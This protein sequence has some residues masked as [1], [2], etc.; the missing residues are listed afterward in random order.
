MKAYL[1]EI[2]LEDMEVP[3]TDNVFNGPNY[4]DETFRFLV[5]DETLSKARYSAIT[6]LPYDYLECYELT[7]LDLFRSTKGKRTRRKYNYSQFN[8]R[9]LDTI[10]SNYFRDPL[11]G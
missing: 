6:C 10:F 5:I 2:K 3:W 11:F 4:R 1:I 8:I 9:F 7:P